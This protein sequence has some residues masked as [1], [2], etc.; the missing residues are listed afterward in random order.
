MKTVI[1][2]LIDDIESTGNTKNFEKNFTEK[3]KKKFFFSIWNLKNF[4][5]NIK[6]N[7][8]LK[9]LPKKK[10]SFWK[11]DEKLLKKIKKGGTRKGLALEKGWLKSVE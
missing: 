10:Y 7:Q 11:V 4:F 2:R 8:K 9:R 5:F 1:Y 3:L 6:K